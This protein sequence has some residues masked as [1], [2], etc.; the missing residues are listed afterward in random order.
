MISLSSLTLVLLDPGEKVHANFIKHDL[1]RG[2]SSRHKLQ[3]T[4]DGSLTG[5]RA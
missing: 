5:Q 2:L 3:A 1:A 4:A